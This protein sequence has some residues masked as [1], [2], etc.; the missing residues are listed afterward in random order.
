MTTMF[1][2]AEMMWREQRMVCKASK[3]GFINMSNFYSGC[4][5]VEMRLSKRLFDASLTAE[6][7]PCICRIYVRHMLDTEN[8]SGV[9]LRGEL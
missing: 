3:N 5:G 9:L 2:A 4:R 1:V 7:A 8:V 6:N